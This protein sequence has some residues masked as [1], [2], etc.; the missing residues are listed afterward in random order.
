M[1]PEER[2]KHEE[3]EKKRKEKEALDRK[4]EDEVK[5]ESMVAM[6]DC[7]AKKGLGIEGR[8]VLAQSIGRALTITKVLE[9]LTGKEV[10]G[11]DEKA[12]DKHLE[13]KTQHET[14]AFIALMAI[15]EDVEYSTID[16]AEDFQLMCKALGL[17]LKEVAKKVKEKLMAEAKAKADAEKAAQAAKD[18]KPAKNS[19]DPTDVN[20]DK[21]VSKTKAADAR[22]KKHGTSANTEDYGLAA[23]KRGISVGTLAPGAFGKGPARVAAEKVSKN[24]R[25]GETAEEFKAREA[26]RVADYKAARKAK[27]KG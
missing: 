8:K 23:A 13:G 27:A 26:K 16:K 11:D 12:L 5:R 19:T 15:Y 18:K 9:T 17:N 3:S 25:E 24:Q 21:E 4:I 20:T 2:R 10:L 1:T 14:D 6:H 22:A 7:I